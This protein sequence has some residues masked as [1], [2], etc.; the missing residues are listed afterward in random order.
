MIKPLLVTLYFGISF[1]KSS[2]LATPFDEHLIK[3]TKVLN[4]A[5]AKV[6]AIQHQQEYHV[7]GPIKKQ[8]EVIDPVNNSFHYW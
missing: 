8:I 1:L 2:F 6:S 5:F 4:E 3:T 7:K